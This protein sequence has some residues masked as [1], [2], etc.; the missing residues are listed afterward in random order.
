MDDMSEEAK[1]R[2]E[3]KMMSEEALLPIRVVGIDP[4]LSGAIGYYD[5]RTSD[6]F[7]MPIRE[8]PSTT[9]KKKNE[10]DGEGLVKLLKDLSPQVVYLERV[11][12]M[13]G[14]GVSS[15]FNFGEGWGRIRGI[16][17]AMDIQYSL[18]QPTQW[19]RSVGIPS[20]ANKDASL[21]LAR[22]LFPERADDLKLKKHDGRAEALLIATHGYSKLL[23]L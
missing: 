16:L 4:G 6:V 14:Q 2:R 22:S 12:S 7:D 17:E 23:G 9:K 11:A 10:I 5:G 3:A 1:A 8:K 19:K 21:D 20:G 13:P 15:T 18:V